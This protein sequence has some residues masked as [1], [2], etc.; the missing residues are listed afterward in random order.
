MSRRRGH[1]R[2]GPIVV[3]HETSPHVMVRRTATGTRVIVLGGVVSSI[4]AYLFQILGARGLGEDAY[5]PVGILWTLQYLTLTVALVSVEAHVTSREGVTRGALAWIAGLAVAVGV[6]VALVPAPAL[7]TGS[8]AWPWAA[9]AI[10]IGF[11][12]FVVVRGQLA[13]QQAYRGYGLMT[14]GESVVRL[15]VA[16]VLIGVGGG[17]SALAFTLPAGAALVTLPF[18][19]R[20]R[21]RRPDRGG[22]PQP[23]ALPFLLR[24]TLANGVAQ[25]LLAAGPLVVALLGGADAVVTMVFVTTTAARAPMVLIHSGTLARILP[26]M[27]RMVAEGRSGELTAIL[28]RAALPALLVLLVLAGIGAVLGPPLVALTFGAALRPSALFAG[29]T[30]ASVGLAMI[31][32]VVN[33]VVIAG[34]GERRLVLP[35]VLGLSAAL[36]ALAAP[37]APV[38]VRVATASVVGLAVAVGLVA[39][40]LTRAAA[41]HAGQDHSPLS[42]APPG[43]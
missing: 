7:G 17:A 29:L 6:G 27:R 34:D 14:G 23:A 33:Q 37:V 11:G 19:G 16:A 20:L 36:G 31:A 25:V 40:G 2:A 10:V 13:A 30:T 38:E 8:A 41:H 26:P 1:G 18:L 9:A 3:A 24:T 5:A 12:M 32:L 15:V 42:Q 28:R 43:L 4:A 35:W 39:H 22:L 21:T